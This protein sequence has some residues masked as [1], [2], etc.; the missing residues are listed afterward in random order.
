MAA[1]M[2]G[3]GAPHRPVLLRETIELLD[4]ARGGLFVDGTLG[5]GGHSEAILEASPET[6]VIGI[7][8]DREALELAQESVWRDSA[9]AFGPSMRTSAKS[10]G[11]SRRQAS[12]KCAACWLTW[13]FRRFSSTPG[14]R[15]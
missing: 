7:D 3:M 12:R 9:R 5:L 8:R 13:A 1:L 4:A 6:R 14:A 11:W 10:R 2:G 15:L